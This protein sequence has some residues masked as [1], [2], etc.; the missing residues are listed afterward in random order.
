VRVTRTSAR[1]HLP[2]YREPA[3][4]NPQAEPARTFLIVSAIPRTV[5]PSTCSC[6][7][8]GG[9][10]S[11]LPASALLSCVPHRVLRP[12]EGQGARCV[13]PTSATRTILRLPIPRAFLVRSATF[14]AWIPHGVLGSVLFARGPNASRALGT[15]RRIFNGHTLPCPSN[16][17]VSRRGA[18]GRG[19]SL[20]TAPMRIVPLTPLSRIPYCRRNNRCAF[21]LPF[22][23]THVP[24]PRC[25]ASVRDFS[26]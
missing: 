3:S 18:L 4:R 12:E 8:S 22:S 7:A 20:S 13:R 23:V 1:K 16:L 6:P 9:A 17:R 25:L 10:S 26:A 11:F 24:L 15:L 5:S 21:A 2:L 14:I 19:R